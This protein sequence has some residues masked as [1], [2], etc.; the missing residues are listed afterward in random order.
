ME[1][2]T[3]NTTEDIL[4]SLDGVKRAA[5]PDFFYTRLVA[6]MEKGLPV[7]T[8][9]GWRL[10][11]VFV[12]AALLIVLAVNAVVF[13]QRQNNG[14]TVAATDTDES[15]QQSIAAEYNLNDNNTIYDLNQDK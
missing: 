4:N 1:N 11:P 14:D 3:N 6:R 15:F 13:L 8:N 7:A 9:S 10:K 5:A 2:K 12:M